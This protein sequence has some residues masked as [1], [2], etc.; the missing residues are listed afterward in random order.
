MIDKFK[1]WLGIEGLKVDLLIP[2]SIKAEDGFVDGRLVFTTKQ[3]QTVS[4]IELTI[5]EK[6][7]RGRGRDTKVDE[8]LIGSISM[9]DS[10]EVKAFQETYIDFALPFDLDS[11]SIDQLGEK[12]ILAKGI[13]KAAKAI[14]NVSSEYKVTVRAKVKGTAL[15]PFDEQWLSI[16]R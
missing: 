11:S 16:I 2:E 3:M 14:H 1:N 8:Y 13:A 12:N 7:S 5:H 9:D 6:Y 10:F 4:R 15:D